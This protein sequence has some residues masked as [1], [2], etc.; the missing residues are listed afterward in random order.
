MI[1]DRRVIY[2]GFTTAFLVFLIF[3][4]VMWI[5]MNLSYGFYQK[6]ALEIAQNHTGEERKFIQNLMM[7]NTTNYGSGGISCCNESDC[8]VTSESIENGH[9]RA[10]LG[11]IENGAWTLGP[12]VDIPDEKI[13][14]HLPKEGTHPGHPIICERSSFGNRLNAYMGSATDAE[15]KP[16]WIQIFCFVRGAGT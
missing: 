12:W 5:S 2:C 16:S 8:H 10:Q 11:R 3:M 7:P 6:G 13:V 15:T 1:V 14:Q 9:Y 4:L